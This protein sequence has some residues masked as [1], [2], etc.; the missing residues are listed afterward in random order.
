MLDRPAP[1]P[2]EIVS[3]LRAER[4]GLLYEISP[5]LVEVVLELGVSVRARP[6]CRSRVIRGRGCPVGGEHAAPGARDAVVWWIGRDRR[7]QWR[8]GF[9]GASGDLLD[10]MAL[11]YGLGARRD[12]ARV[13]VLARALVMRL[14]RRR[15]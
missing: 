14:R 3:K 2:T 4:E 1:T 8:C 6:G 12:L 11:V 7:A 13:V 15:G 9:C 10:A 5:Y